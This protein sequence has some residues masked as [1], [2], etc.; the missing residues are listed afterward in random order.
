MDFS[1]HQRLYHK[2]N[3]QELLALIFSLSIK[4]HLV[5]YYILQSENGQV[6]EWW[7]CSPEV[8]T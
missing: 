2:P 6:V 1:K 8:K 3:H 5:F 7:I 4:K